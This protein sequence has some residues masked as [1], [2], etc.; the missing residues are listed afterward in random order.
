VQR[1]VEMLVKTPAEVVKRVS[2]ATNPK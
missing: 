1:I 2:E